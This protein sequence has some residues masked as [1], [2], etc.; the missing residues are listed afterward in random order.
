[1]PCFIPNIS[2]S[3]S[4]IWEIHV[5]LHSTPSTEI[6]HCPDSNI[7][8]QMF[9]FSFHSTSALLFSFAPHASVI[10]D[11]YW[12]LS[13]YLWNIFKFIL[14][15]SCLI[16]FY[17]SI[18]G[19]IGFFPSCLFSFIFPSLYIWQQFVNRFKL[20]LWLFI[21]IFAYFVLECGLFTLKIS[22]LYSK[23]IFPLWRKFHALQ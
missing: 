6:H 23:P 1:M 17:Y 11:L 4:T 14:M 19:C 2:S 20:K 12:I 9:R 10:F 8:F 21:F 5:Y 7:Y 18:L 3:F 15:I 16:S 22:F 13:Q